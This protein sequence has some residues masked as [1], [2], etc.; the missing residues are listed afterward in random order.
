LR[1]L[2]AADASHHCVGGMQA[3]RHVLLWRKGCRWL[4]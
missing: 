1:Q 4:W 2:T 3:A